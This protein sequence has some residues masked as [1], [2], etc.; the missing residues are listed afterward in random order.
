MSKQAERGA[1]LSIIGLGLIGGSLAL[2]LRS[3]GYRHRII[4]CDRDASALAL[5]RSKGAIDA[6]FSDPAEAVADADMIILALPMGAIQEVMR[7]MSPTLQESAII[8]DVASVKGPIVALARQELSAH[9]PRFVPGH[10]IAGT[11]HSGMK[12]AFAEMFTGQLVLLT[13]S[14]DTA[15]EAVQSVRALWQQT[16]AEIDCLDTGRH[17]EILAATSHLPHLL[18]YTLVACLATQKDQEQIFR[19][20]AG[21]FADFTRIAAS[22]PRLWRDI[23]LGNREPLLR[24]LESFQT[25]L[26]LMQR[27]IETNDTDTLLN[28][29]LAAKAA[30]DQFPLRANRAMNREDAGG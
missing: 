24:V 21:G 8:S 27:A 20:T 14:A 4:G 18:A 6:G 3:A 12:A 10:P 11:E 22:D 17:D 25:Q 30:R 5:A 26:A 15:S 2:A 19:C 9:L 23:C 16:G 13:P 28:V 1:T 29:F 7:A